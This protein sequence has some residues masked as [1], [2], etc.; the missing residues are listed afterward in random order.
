MTENPL[1]ASCAWNGTACTEGNN[2]ET[3]VVDGGSKS[4]DCEGIY[5]C[6]SCKS[7]SLQ[8]KWCDGKCKK[9][10]DC[11]EVILVETRM[12]VVETDLISVS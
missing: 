1:G 4:S 3:S 9:S 11:G 7:S 10:A 8:C 12:L 6:S 2:T 5:H